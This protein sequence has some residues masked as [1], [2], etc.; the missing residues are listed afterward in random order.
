MAFESDTKPDIDT[1]VADL[2]DDNG[3]VRQKACAALSRMGP[4]A[5]PTL[6]SLLGDENGMTRTAAM[7]ALLTMRDPI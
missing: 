6:V 1:L 3:N 4:A 7:N 5:V 2:K